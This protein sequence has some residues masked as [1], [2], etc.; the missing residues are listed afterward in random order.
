MMSF[1]EIT[2][3]FGDEERTVTM[4]KSLEELKNVVANEFT[5]PG[6][7]LFEFIYIDKVIQKSFLS[8]DEQGTIATSVTA[9]V[10]KVRGNGPRLFEANRPFLFLIRNTLLPT[11]YEMLFMSKVE[12]LS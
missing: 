2:L 9:E 10:I 12:D 7:S 4:P 11:N 3:I 6:R 5:L 8:V 1:F